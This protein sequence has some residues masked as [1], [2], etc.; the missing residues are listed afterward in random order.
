MP[1]FAVILLKR[2][3]LLIPVMILVVTMVFMLVHLVPG[4]PARLIVGENA[5]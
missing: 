3:L 5:S 4:D 2:L 1:R